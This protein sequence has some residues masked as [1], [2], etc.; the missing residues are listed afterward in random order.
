MNVLGFLHQGF[1]WYLGA[2]GSTCDETCS[3]LGSTNEALAAGNV[4][5][6]EDCTVIEHF[7]TDQGLGLSGRAGT[8]VWSFGYY[9]TGT[10]KYYCSKFGSIGFGTRIGEDNSSGTRALVCACSGN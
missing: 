4:I 8:A 6:E 10:T 9:Y 5:Q 1:C 2:A 7:N 3:N